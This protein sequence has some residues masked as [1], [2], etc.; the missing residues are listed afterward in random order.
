MKEGESSFSLDVK[1]GDLQEA[2]NLDRWFHRMVEFY[3]VFP[4]MSVAINEKGGVC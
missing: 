4:S 3:I 2:V 1:G